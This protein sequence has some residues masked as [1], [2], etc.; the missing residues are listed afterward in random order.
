MAYVVAFR[1]HEVTLM[2]TDMWE[3][4]RILLWKS[5][6]ESISHSVVSDSLRPPGL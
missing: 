2:R 5:E 3:I 4:D 1:P 6:S